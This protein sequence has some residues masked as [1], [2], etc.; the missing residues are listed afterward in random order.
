MSSGALSAT[1][2][3]LDVIHEIPV[4]QRRPFWKA[5]LM[6]IFIT[7]GAIALLT[8]ASFLVLLGDSMVKVGLDLAAQLPFNPTGL[9]VLVILWR[10]IE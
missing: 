3:A 8:F 7:I 9:S 10:L 6:S 2:N 5:K 1:M 4:K